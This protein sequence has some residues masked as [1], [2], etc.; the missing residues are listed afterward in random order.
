MGWEFVSAT[1]V[2]N[3]KGNE[4]DLLTTPPAMLLG[5]LR[6]AVHRT[7]EKKAHGKLYPDSGGNLG[8]DDIFRSQAGGRI[9]IDHAKAS[10]AAKKRHEGYWVAAGVLA[11]GLWTGQQASA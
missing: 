7:H 11:E 4:V 3:D 1:V 9:C 10:G 2:K 5:L 6:Q 8:A